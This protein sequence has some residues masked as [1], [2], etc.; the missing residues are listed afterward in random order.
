[1]VVI[2]KEPRSRRVEGDSDE[3]VIGASG[4]ANP[5][6]SGDGN[7]GHADGSDVGD[8]EGDSVPV[9]E[10]YVVDAER[11]HANAPEDVYDIDHIDDDDDDDIEIE[12]DAAEEDI[13]ESLAAM[14]F[15]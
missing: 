15:H 2:Q 11:E 1:M 13:V 5:V 9:Q 4:Y 14:G 6:T 7:V 10:V 3:I 8:H 12:E